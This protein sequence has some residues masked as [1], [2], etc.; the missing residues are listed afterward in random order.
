MKLLATSV[1]RGARQGESH[2]GVYL[3]DF[4]ERRAERVIDWDTAGIDWRGRGWDRGLRGIACHGEQV[5]I[6]ASDE[7]F[8]YDPGFRRTA[9]WRNRYLKHCHEIA[10]AGGTLFLASTGYDSI[11][12]FDLAGEAFVWGLH[13]R[14]DGE[15]IAVTTFDPRSDD[16][17]APANAF[18]LNSV[19]ADDGG[20]FLAGLRTPGLMRWGGERLGMVATLPEGS[21]NARPF[22]DGILFNDTA[23][24]TVRYVTPSRQRGFR[25]PAYADDRVT[26][27]EH[28]DGRVARRHF[29]R[30][31]C[32]VGGSL[33][34]GGSS[35]STVALH[36]LD[37]NRTTVMVTLSTDVRNAIHGLAPWPF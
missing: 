33:V 6:A 14:R 34:A 2:G 26:G 17:P 35:P 30:G 9:S 32:P 10:R 13:L 24:D 1:V 19:F 20:L 36:D 29:A 7:L 37:A 15:R 8:A 5:L 22:R 12:A 31:L 16:G 3:V 18:H 21:H 25:V 27:R 23:I 28:E 4:A 11:L